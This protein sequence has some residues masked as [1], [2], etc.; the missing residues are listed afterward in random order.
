MAKCVIVMSYFTGHSCLSNV[1]FFQ[2]K[3]LCSNGILDNVK[4][5]FFVCASCELDKHHVL[6][7]NDNNFVS[8]T[9]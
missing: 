4:N 6:P 8:Y 7:F 3:S 5:E 2:L 9:N 1:S